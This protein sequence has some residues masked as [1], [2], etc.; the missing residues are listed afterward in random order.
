MLPPEPF[1]ADAV[2]RINARVPQVRQ[3]L[4]DNLSIFPQYPEV[5]LLKAG[6]Q[7]EGIRLEHNQD[8]YFLA[9]YAPE[10]AWGSQE[11][12]MRFQR[13]DGL[14]PF[15]L[16]RLYQQKGD[17]F[18]GYPCCYWH[19][20]TIWPFAR[21]AMEIARRTGRPEA[22]FDRIYRCA[23]AYDNW[24]VRHRCEAESGLPAM[25]C[26]YDTGHDNAPR[27]TD[28]GIPHSC[29]DLDA[30]NR[31]D[32]PIMPILS[33]DLSA[34]LYGGRTALA[35]LAEQLGKSAEAAEWRAKAGATRLAIR[36]FLYDE[37]D[38]FYYDRSPAGLRKYRTEH[39]TRLFL[40]QVLTQEE[41]DR[42]YER[43]F[44][45]PGRE[46]LP[47][48]PLPSSSIDDPS[49]RHGVRNCW[50]GNTQALTSLRALFWMKYYHR[51]ADR[52]ALLLRWMKAFEEHPESTFQ[53]ELDP[54]TGAP[55]GDGVNYTPTVLLFLEAARLP[56]FA[57][58]R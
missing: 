36:H 12:F 44:C 1:S 11:A 6:D 46:F 19:V 43:Y 8:N 55:I 7:Y 28:G 31:P 16:P 23:A 33:V 9:E 15:A 53:Q 14:L 27:V 26:E 34:A 32:L 29:P 5:P 48:Y 22:D 40:N 10:S 2:S 35:E 41:F 58:V 52:E 54:F 21:C 39:V 37:A 18:Y 56:Q 17:Y 51:E 47:P 13:A 38:E 50:G 49:F 25:F 57:S 4:L 45:T 3:A 24:F 20:Q 42:V 30:N